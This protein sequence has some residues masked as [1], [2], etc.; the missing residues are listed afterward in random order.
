[1]FVR[2]R[3]KP[4]TRRLVHFQY[5]NITLQYAHL[6]VIHF[7]IV[8]INGL[9]SASLHDDTI[10]LET[11]KRRHR[12]R[13]NGIAHWAHVSANSTIFRSMNRLH[14]LAQARLHSL[15]LRAV[16]RKTNEND[17]I[18]PEPVTE[19]AVALRRL[20]SHFSIRFINSS[21]RSFNWSWMHRKLNWMKLTIDDDGTLSVHF[22]RP[23]CR[24]VGSCN[25]FPYTQNSRH[26]VF[27]AHFMLV[28]VNYIR[29]SST[30]HARTQLTFR[31]RC[32]MK[33]YWHFHVL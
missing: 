30:P 21:Y 23:F 12:P 24:L 5:R 26:K 11:I 2:H 32:A 16:K 20:R 15:S 31:S 1:M 14:A 29:H 13:Q 22:E 33:V 27:S 17:S 9:V 25:T 10:R 19:T 6:N 8:D 3:L 7:S 18:D 28:P 4:R